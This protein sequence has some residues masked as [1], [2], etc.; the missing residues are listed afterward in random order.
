MKPLLQLQL[1]AAS[2]DGL[3]TRGIQSLDRSELDKSRDEIIDAPNVIQSVKSVA[4]GSNYNM[5]TVW[6]VLSNEIAVS[7]WCDRVPLTRQKQGW[8]I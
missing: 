8:N 4:A 5:Q 1:K 2:M 6:K 3:H 7:R